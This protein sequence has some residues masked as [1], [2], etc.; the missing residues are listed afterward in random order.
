MSRW[1]AVSGSLPSERVS[2]SSRT[3]RRVPG[4]SAMPLS[5][6]VLLKVGLRWGGTWVSASS[7][8]SGNSELALRNDAPAR[9]LADQGQ[10]PAHGLFAETLREGHDAPV[11]GRRR[12]RQLLQSRAGR[13]AGRHF[14]PALLGERRRAAAVG[15]LEVRRIKGQDLV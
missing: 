11:I 7:A 2:R 8:G 3:A 9:R 6:A 15:R 10:F 13:L 12:R 4:C 14:L 1:V 5:R